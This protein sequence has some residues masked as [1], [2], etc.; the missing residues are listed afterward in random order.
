VTFPVRASARPLPETLAVV[1]GVFK[2]GAVPLHFWVPD[3]AQSA[4]PTTAA[5]P[6][7][8]A[9]DRRAGDRLPACHALPVNTLASLFYYLRW[10]APAY[11]AGDSDAPDSAAS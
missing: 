8:G 11:R 9:E 6:H 4:G 1:F 10:V 7:H 5:F 3:V 2:A